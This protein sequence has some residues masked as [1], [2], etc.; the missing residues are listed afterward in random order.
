M[1][2]R[3][4]DSSNGQ[5]VNYG[6]R[7]F[8]VKYLNEISN[9]KPL[10]IEEE[11]ELFNRIKTSNDKEAIDKI[12]KH[13]LLFVVSV[14]R[15]YS[16]SLMSTTIT[17]E[18]LIN[19]GNIGLFEAISGFD[20]SKGYKFISYAVWHIRKRILNSMQNNVKTIRIP[21]GVRSEITKIKNKEMKMEQ[22]YE[23]PVS[24]LEVFEAMLK[25]GEIKE[26]DTV[27]K[28]DNILKM[29]HFEK[30]LSNKISNDG[31]MELSETIVD[32]DSTSALDDILKQ[33]KRELVLGLL[34]KIPSQDRAYIMDFFGFETNIPLSIKEIS[35]KY[36]KTSEYIRIHINKNLRWLKATSRSKKR[37]FTVD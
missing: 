10:T 3:Q 30:S 7:D 36:N 8:Y 21:T 11:T 37:F 6:N 18:D 27:E 35:E 32:D 29:Y 1:K 33:E 4:K 9:F 14:A 25:D 34:S 31:D 13:N 28:F 26:T 19:E 20:T 16:V 23:R 17:L 15:H 2:L 5:I 22:L 12:M 24:T